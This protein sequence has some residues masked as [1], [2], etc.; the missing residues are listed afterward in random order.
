MKEGEYV[1]TKGFSLEHMKI[2]SLALNKY[3]KNLHIY[4]LIQINEHVGQHTGTYITPVPCFHIYTPV[5]S[6]FS[7]YV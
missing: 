2:H 1:Q 6:V 7:M 3:H 4:I 5:I